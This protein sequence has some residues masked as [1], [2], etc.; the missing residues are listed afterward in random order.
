MPTTK[1]G[2]TNLQRAL[3]FV[4]NSSLDTKK[5]PFDQSIKVINSLE[6]SSLKN[7]D[8]E[9]RYRMGDGILLFY[10]GVSRALLLQAKSHIR[11]IA[12]DR[13]D[14]FSRKFLKLIKRHSDKFESA[15]HRGYH[16]WRICPAG[17]NL[18]IE[19]LDDLPK[20]SSMQQ[21]NLG[22]GHPRHFSAEIRRLAYDQ[23]EKDGSNC[24]GFGRER[25]F[26][27]IKEGDR[28][29][30]DHILPAAKGGSNSEFNVQVL[31]ENCNRKKRDHIA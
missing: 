2:Y 8:I 25:H 31:C 1:T 30:Y 3:D 7:A 10:Q 14:D 19:F 28:I 29:E 16:Q 17:A 15:H 26:I 27:D 21:S 24:P 6:S 9:I 13:R 4:K 12:W 11:M 20:P 23:F 22:M 5:F 18:F